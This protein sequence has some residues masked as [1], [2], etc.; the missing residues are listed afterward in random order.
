MHYTHDSDL[1]QLFM[2]LAIL[3]QKRM[4]PTLAWRVA[5]FLLQAHMSQIVASRNMR[6]VLS[7]TLTAFER[8]QEE[9]RDIVGFN[10][11]GL[12]IMSR[13]A[14][15]IE[16]FTYLDEKIDDRVRQRQDFECCHIESF[17]SPC[18]KL[19]NEPRRLE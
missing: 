7:D 12:E 6:Q 1:P 15:E 16:Q 19:D 2:F 10:L 3:L 4:Q 5:Y 18:C 8:W 13:E 17:R 14:R 11:A 9:E